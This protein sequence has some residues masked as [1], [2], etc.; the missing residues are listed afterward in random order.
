MSR[1]AL[2][3]ADRGFAR[4]I[5]H[6]DLFVPNDKGGKDWFHFHDLR[7]TAVTRY[8]HKPYKLG[9][10]QYNYL[11]GKYLKH[12]YVHINHIEWCDDMR[13]DIEA[14]DARLPDFLQAASPLTVVNMKLE[15]LFAGS[16]LDAIY[17]QSQSAYR[18]WTDLQAS[19]DNSNASLSLTK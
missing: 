5:R 6:T 18:E 2:D 19:N 16:T 11:L 8:K 10:D 15:G 12:K 4:I 9:A 17:K 13:K 7:H 14:G 3:W 1:S